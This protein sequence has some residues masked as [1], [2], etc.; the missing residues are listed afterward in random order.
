MSNFKE[1]GNEKSV[2]N[3][4]NAS[5]KLRPLTFEHYIGQDHIKEELKVAIKASKMKNEQLG[6]MLFFGAPGL[7]KTTIAKI[8]ANAKEANLHITSAP[9]IERPADLASTLMSLE[10]GDI[11]FIDEIHALKTKIEESLYSVMEDFTLDINI[12]SGNGTK[13]IHLPIKK[14]TLIAATTRP[15]S[16]SQPLRDRF[17]VIHQLKFYT[18][19]ELAQILSRSADILE[20]ELEFEAA[21][22]IA[23]RSRSTARIANNLLGRL[24]PYALVN[25]NA[26]IDKDFAIE[27]LDKL[28]IDKLGLNDMDRKML[29][30]MHYGFKDRAVGLKAISPYISEEEKTIEYV[31]EPFLI[32]KGLLSKTKGGRKLTEKGIAY[33]KE[34]IPE[35]NY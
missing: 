13:L 5:N 22:E 14:F 27:T 32:K 31:I 9:I 11:L 8:I 21:V 20:V 30:C 24:R 4:E 19:E 29:H 26:K 12:D 18:N 28:L 3:E 33:T 35:E 17:N 1:Q 10:E 2:K 7:G 25:N 23:K 6:H 16:I 34:N 15:G